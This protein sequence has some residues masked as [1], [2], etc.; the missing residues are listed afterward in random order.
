MEREQA[1]ER[2]REREREENIVIDGGEREIE[3]GGVGKEQSERNKRIE[4][5]FGGAEGER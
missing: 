4:R 2:E 3:K 1:L 5:E